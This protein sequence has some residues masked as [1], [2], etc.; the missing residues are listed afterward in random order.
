MSTTEPI[1]FVWKT[2]FQPMYNHH[3]N[4]RIKKGGLCPC[5]CCVRSRKFTRVVAKLPPKDKKWMTTLYNSLIQAE[6]DVDY[7]TL[8]AGIRKRE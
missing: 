5:A 8:I 1:L 2:A 4:P 7:Y 6:D 3:N